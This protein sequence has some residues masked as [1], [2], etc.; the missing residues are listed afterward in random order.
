[1]E[2]LLCVSPQGRIGEQDRYNPCLHGDFVLPTD[3]DQ[4]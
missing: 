4:F 3:G 2:H 1:M